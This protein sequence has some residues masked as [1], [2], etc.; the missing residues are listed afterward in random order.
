MEPQDDTRYRTICPALF[1]LN[2]VGSELPDLTID[3]A[4][5]CAILTEAFR[6]RSVFSV[7]TKGDQING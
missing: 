7:F 1:P 2:G 5:G 4:I 3:A 6:N